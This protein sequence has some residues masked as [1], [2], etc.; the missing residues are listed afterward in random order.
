LLDCRWWEGKS[1]WLYQPENDWAK[2]DQIVANHSDLE[3]MFEETL[4][5][6]GIK[7]VEP[8]IALE[9]KRTLIEESN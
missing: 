7:S 5:A 8:L 6:A 2:E 3:V 9:K 4:R 1:A